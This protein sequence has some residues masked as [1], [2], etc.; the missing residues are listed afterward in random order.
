MR[1]FN[2]EGK[3]KNGHSVVLKLEYRGVKILLGGDLNTPAEEYLLRH[4]TGLDPK[5]ETPEDEQELI[6]RARETF[7]ADVAKACHHG[8]ADFTDLFL[9]AVNPTATIVSSGD[10]ESHAHPRPDSLGALGKNGRGSR[11]LIFSTELARS[12]TETNTRCQ[13]IRDKITKLSVLIE[14]TEDEDIRAV[15]KAE[16]KKLQEDSKGS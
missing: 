3:T 14:K 10:N 8:S 11:P 4:Y 6:A 7:E 5:P 16:I 13:A 2:D 15:L 1:W 9:R 12:V